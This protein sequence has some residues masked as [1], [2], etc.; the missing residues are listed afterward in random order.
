MGR[1]FFKMGTAIADMTP[2]MEIVM[3][4]S[5]RVSPGRNVSIF[6]TFGKLFD[7]DIVN[8]LKVRLLRT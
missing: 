2:T 8:V 5:I 3:R 6:E 1:R 7:R 4:S